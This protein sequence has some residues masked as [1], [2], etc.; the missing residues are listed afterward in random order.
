MPS[1]SHGYSR[2]LRLWVTLPYNNGSSLRTLIMPCTVIAH[3]MPAQL[4]Y[5][6][7]R[8][9][10]VQS[11]VSNQ[12]PHLMNLSITDKRYHNITASLITFNHDWISGLLP[13]FKITSTRGAMLWDTRPLSLMM[14]LLLSPMEHENNTLLVFDADSELEQRLIKAK[15]N[16]QAVISAII[17]EGLARISSA[18]PTIIVRRPNKTTTKVTELGVAWTDPSSALTGPDTGMTW[19][20]RE[21]IY[22]PSMD[23]LT[24]LT[25]LD[26][27]VER[28]GYGT[29]GPGASKTINGARLFLS[30][31]L[32][33]MLIYFLAA[34]V[35]PWPEICAWDDLSDLVMLAWNSTST[36]QDL[37]QSTLGVWYKRYWMIWL[38]I[39]VDDAT[40]KP[41][42]VAAGEGEKKLEEDVKYQ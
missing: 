22:D 39:R 15:M 30:C 6:P 33:I 10:K 29:G 17:T 2:P 31:Y 11:N 32:F 16:I 7:I 24:S 27:Y 23:L 4:I 26:F 13:D 34:L 28:H 3:W 40:G 21:K 9:E 12:L 20:V 1:T 38:G 35:A 36:L 14:E 5:S 42:L 25:S 41:M 37:K 19:D 8:S 18:A